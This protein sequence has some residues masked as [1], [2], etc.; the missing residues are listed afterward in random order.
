MF[1]S[2]IFLSGP[3]LREVSKKDAVAFQHQ[4]QSFKYLNQQ[5]SS[6]RFALMVK[7]VCLF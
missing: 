2:F 1:M 4:L 5:G 6:V 7:Q 3:R